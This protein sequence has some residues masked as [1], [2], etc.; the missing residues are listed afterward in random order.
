MLLPLTVIGSQLGIMTAN[1]TLFT[2]ESAGLGGAGDTFTYLLSIRIPEPGSMAVLGAGLAG[3]ACFR[4]RR[5][6]P[7]AA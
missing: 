1:L 3:L 2:D 5:R 6:S 4:R 7:A